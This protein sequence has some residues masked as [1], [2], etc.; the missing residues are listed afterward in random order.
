MGDLKDYRDEI[1]NIDKELISLFE[2]RMN[3]AKK[4][5][6]YKK[7]NNLPILNEEREKQVIIKNVNLLQN[8]EYSK[9]TQAFFEK[10]MELSRSIQDELI[11]TNEI[12]SI[13]IGYQGVE[14][15]LVKRHL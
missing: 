3:I 14:G 11:N 4:V 12:E 7:A 9:I 6:E 1:D 10:I 2:R 15:S 13:K 8:K 5:A